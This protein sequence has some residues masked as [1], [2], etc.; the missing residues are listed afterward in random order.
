[1]SPRRRG[2]RVVSVAGPT[3]RERRIAVFGAVAVVATTVLAVWLLRP[4]GFHPAGLSGGLANRQPRAT[5]LVVLALAAL[6]GAF[7]FFRTRRRPGGAFN[8][9]GLA[10]AGV[11]ILVAAVAAGFVWPAGLL[12]SYVA[13]EPFVPPTVPASSSTGP[14]SSTSPA[15]T[16]TPSGSSVATSTPPVSTTTSGGG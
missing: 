16:S 13:P 6:V 14:P 10:A 11:A 1:M 2:R 5:W 12:R 7:A 15:S 8:R 3:P 4:G 9:R